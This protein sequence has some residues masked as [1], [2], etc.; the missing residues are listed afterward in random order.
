MKSVTLSD[1]EKLYDLPLAN[2]AKKLGIGKSILKKKCRNFGFSR[3]PYRKINS[4]NKLITVAEVNYKLCSSICFSAQ[5]VPFLILSSRI[6]NN[7]KPLLPARSEQKKNRYC[8]LNTHCNIVSL[9]NGWS[10][11]QIFHK[12]GRILT[13][14]Y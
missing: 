10:F 7:F 8:I 2:A 1:V 3:W 6:N 11:V 13:F 12:Y 5:F 9:S 14:S 4:I